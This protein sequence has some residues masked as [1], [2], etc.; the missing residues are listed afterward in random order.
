MIRRRISVLP[1]A[2]RLPLNLSFIGAWQ[3]VWAIVYVIFVVNAVSHV[4]VA[5]DS[6]TEYRLERP[7]VKR[8]SGKDFKAALENRFSINSARQPANVTLRA[9][10]DSQK[11]CIVLDRR[12]DR[13]KKIRRDITGLSLLTAVQQ[14]AEDLD[15]AASI[16]GNTIYVGPR[17]SASKLQTLIEIQRTRSELLD[18]K[19]RA[20]MNRGRPLHWDDLETSQAILDRCLKTYRLESTGESLPHDL[21]QWNSLV[22]L[23]VFEAVSLVL[24]QFDLTFELNPDGESIVIQPVPEV[25]SVTRS[26]RVSSQTT[27]EKALKMC[28]QLFGDESTEVAERR[29]RFTGTTEQHQQV[30]LIVRG[31]QPTQADPEKSPSGMSTIPLAKR[32][33]SLPAQTVPVIALITKLKES[34]IDIQYDPQKFKA[35]GLTLNQR[36]RLEFKNAD[37]NEVFKRI[38]D[39]TG[40]SYTIVGE[41][42]TLTP[43]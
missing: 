17:D 34:G 25:V 11:V 19:R 15:A 28:R 32:E 41:T 33:F 4:E 24:I 42:I 30:A 13:Q 20:E 26:Y 5:A 38:C 31:R 2:N 39:Q 18:R 3:R 16:I 14:I 29:L 35:A 37:V 36:V 6:K 9:I 12:I 10:S 40:T 23:D 43:R 7:L 21:W 22:G 27:I 8:H 1:K